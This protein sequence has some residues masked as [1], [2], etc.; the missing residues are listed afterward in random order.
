MTW[1][2]KR[3][4]RWAGRKTVRRA[5]LRSFVSRITVLAFPLAGA[6]L[7]SYGAW[8]IYAP[9]GYI[10][11]GVLLVVLERRIETE[12]TGGDE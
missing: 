9:A 11:G 6:T 10:V 4:Q 2:G 7:V 1:L 5:R 3:R 8:N 12:L